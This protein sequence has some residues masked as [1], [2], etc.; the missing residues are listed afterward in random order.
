MRPMDI[1]GA[2]SHLVKE[3][4]P[5]SRL[6]ASAS[7]MIPE[8]AWLGQCQLEI[9]QQRQGNMT[10]A[11]LTVELEGLGRP[12]EVA[13]KSRCA[14]SSLGS[15]S[16]ATPGPTSSE[17]DRPTPE[18]GASTELCARGRSTFTCRC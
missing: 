3:H 13:A 1:G 16:M 12:N 11:P 8:R 17:M 9:P 4:S 15:Q 2:S 6:V 18:P 5:G 7:V 14:T 10:G